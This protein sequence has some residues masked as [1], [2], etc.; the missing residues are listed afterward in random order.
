ME[1]HFSLTFKGLQI[2]SFA[3]VQNKPLKL[4]D[5]LDI[6]LYSYLLRGNLKNGKQVQTKVKVRDIMPKKNKHEG[7]LLIQRIMKGFT[8]PNQHVLP[9]SFGV[10][11]H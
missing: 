5:N 2:T 9:V 7:N 4:K 11:D 3:N 6:M 8:C 1:V 10:L